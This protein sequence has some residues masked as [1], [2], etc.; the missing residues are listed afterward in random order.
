MF[1]LRPA[2]VDDDA[3]I[4]ET[5]RIAGETFRAIAPA[6]WQP[7]PDEKRL[8]TIRTRL[9][10]PDTWWQIGESDGEISGHVAL[11][12]SQLVTWRPEPAA[13]LAHLWQLFVRPAAWGSGVAVALLQAAVGRA[14]TQGFAQIRL[15]TPYEQARARRFYEREG[16][17]EVG[18]PIDDGEGL[19]IIQY[20]RLLA[21]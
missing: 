16:W 10:D 2:R 18:K 4:C 7:T 8:A 9:A 20:R 17:K 19:P 5:W 12:P 11:L 1:T 15:F 14:T 3:A 21:P 13:D 6:G